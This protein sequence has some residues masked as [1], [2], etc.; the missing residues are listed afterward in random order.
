M[1]TYLTYQEKYMT[2]LIHIIILKFIRYYI[3]HELK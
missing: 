1:Y 2:L 3:K